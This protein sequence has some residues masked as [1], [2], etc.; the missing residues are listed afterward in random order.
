V[1]VCV[2]RLDWIEAWM[3]KVA[4]YLSHEHCAHIHTF[5]PTHGRGGWKMSRD[6]VRV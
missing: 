4:E 6:H 3:N 1:Y 2:C 5:T